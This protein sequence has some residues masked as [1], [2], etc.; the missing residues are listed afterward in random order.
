MAYHPGLRTDAGSK[1]AARQDCFRRCLAATGP[2]SQRPQK[3]G[4]M[5]WPKAGRPRGKKCHWTPE[6]DELLKAAWARG[7]LRRGWRVIRERQPNW[8]QWPIRKRAAT[9]G[10]C[11]PKPRPWTET[12][13]NH[14]LWSL[15]SNASLALIAERLDRTVGAIRQKLRALGY[16]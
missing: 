11:R 6:L 13:E 5:K 9:L 10:L 12:E 14:L 1:G 7:G 16:T 2:S 15:D 3:A 4:S 8:S